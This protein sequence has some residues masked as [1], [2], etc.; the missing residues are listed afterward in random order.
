MFGLTTLAKQKSHSL[1]K[2]T[3]LELRNN[4]HT[5]FIAQPSQFRYTYARVG[6]ISIVK[7]KPTFVIAGTI[8]KHCVIGVI[9][10]VHCLMHSRH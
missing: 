1:S 7:P 2:A 9:A 3:P 8:E 6:V 4:L 10:E 5:K